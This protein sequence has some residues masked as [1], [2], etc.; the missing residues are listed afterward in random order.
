LDLNFVSLIFT[1]RLAE[2]AIQITTIGFHAKFQTIGMFTTNSQA[3]TLELENLVDI[4]TG[5]G[6]RDEKLHRN[7]ND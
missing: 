7:K 5:I 6:V 4:E 3:L 1:S 2:N